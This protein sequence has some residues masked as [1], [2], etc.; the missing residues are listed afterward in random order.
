MINTLPHPLQPPTAWSGDLPVT[1]RYTYG[2]ALE[3]FFLAL[4]EEGKILG[5]RCSQCQKTYVPITEYCPNCLGSLTEI[6]DVG[7]QGEIYSYTILYQNLDG[8]HKESP[9]VIGFIKIADGGLIHRIEGIPVDKI[10]IGTL[11]AAQLI[12]KE[13]RTGSILDIR[14]FKP[15]A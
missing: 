14:S 4:K 2:L 15:L 7:L 12:P 8:S 11:V 5:S 9:E 6:V 3:K 1:N 10:R 13:E